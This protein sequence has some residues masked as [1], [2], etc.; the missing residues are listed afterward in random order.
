MDTGYFLIFNPD[1]VR[2]L[3]SGWRYVYAEIGRKK[4]KA[5]DWAS[6]D[7]ATVGLDIWRLLSPTRADQ[8]RRKVFKRCALRHAAGKRARYRA[9][10]I[11]LRVAS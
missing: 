2:S 5:L 9:A 8:P 10:K 7:A 11:A 1:A 4:V 3:A 6:G